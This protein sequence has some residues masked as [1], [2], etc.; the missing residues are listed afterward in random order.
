MLHTPL[1]VILAKAHTHQLKGFA[2]DLTGV[3]E[4]RLN[5]EEHE[6]HEGHEGGKSVEMRGTD[7]R[8]P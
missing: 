4:L 7:Q 2:W 8:C 1:I 6:D 5:H 3:L